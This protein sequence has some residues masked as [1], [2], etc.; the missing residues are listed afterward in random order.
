MTCFSF[1][2]RRAAE[3]VLDPAGALRAGDVV[4]LACARV[5]VANQSGSFLWAKSGAAGSMD[6]IALIQP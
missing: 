4:H 5:G 6:S 1:I 2:F 3:L